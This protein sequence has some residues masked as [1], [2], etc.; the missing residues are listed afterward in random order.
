MITG[1]SLSRYSEAN[2]QPGLRQ[3]ASLLTDILDKESV[4]KMLLDPGMHGQ[5]LVSWEHVAMC[6]NGLLKTSDSACVSRGMKQ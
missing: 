4:L 6:A 2:L 1:W 3:L 5:Q